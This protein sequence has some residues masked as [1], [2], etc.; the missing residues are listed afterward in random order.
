MKL[1]LVIPVY[2]EE[3]N[4][5]E[6]YETTKKEL[7]KIKYE[8]IF[9][10]DGSKDKSL[11]VLKDLAK[12][13]KKVKIISFSRN[14]GKEA[15][16]YAGLKNITGEYTAIIDSDLQ[17]HPKYL[18]E[19]YNELEESEEYD[20]ICMCQAKRKENFMVSFIKKIGY[21]LMDAVTDVKFVNGASDFRMF[22]RNVLN[23]ILEMSERN[24]FSKGIFSWVGFNTKYMTYEVMERKA[25]KTSWSLKSLISYGVDGFVGFTTKPLRV[26]TYIGFLT[27]LIAFIYFIII[28]LQ[29]LITGKDIPGY[30]SMMCVILF[31]GGIQLLC[32]GIVGEYLA[33][34]YIES[35]ERPIYIEKERINFSDKEN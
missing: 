22:R 25:G 35:K 3:K 16:I 23:A 28:L 5:D 2:N 18:I 31:L 26:S 27:S 9:I 6:F 34:T 8:L 19:M 11:E 32:M 10:N 30:A 33:R 13:D 12:K 20:S 1:S 24:R 14:F 17:Q 7:K 21:R 29:T 15:A 4:L